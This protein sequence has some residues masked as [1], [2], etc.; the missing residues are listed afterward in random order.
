M[1][2]TQEA[3][4]Q[5]ED[6]AFDLILMDCQM[7]EVDGFEATQE[8]RKLKD[9]KKSSVHIVAITANVLP[10]EKKKCFDAGM[11]DFLPKPIKRNDLSQILANISK[12]KKNNSTV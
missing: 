6:R 11:D 4:E 7:P 8:I 2:F 3:I 12:K 10:E 1:I 5:V 9:T